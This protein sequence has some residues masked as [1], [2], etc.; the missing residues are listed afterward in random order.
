MSTLAV[1]LTLVSECLVNGRLVFIPSPINDT[2]LLLWQLPK[3]WCMLLAVLTTL[4]PPVIVGRSEFR[5]ITSDMVTINIRLNRLRLLGMLVIMV[6]RSK[7]IEVV[8]CRFV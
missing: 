2:L 3:A 5:I 7:M 4:S 1:S 6:K 8:L